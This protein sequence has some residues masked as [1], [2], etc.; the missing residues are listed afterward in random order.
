MHPKDLH[1]LSA[2]RLAFRLRIG[3]GE[4]VLPGPTIKL[5][6]FHHHQV[7][8]APVIL[9]FVGDRL[10]LVD[11]VPADSI[12]DVLHNAPGMIATM[13]EK[14]EVAINLPAFER[15]NYRSTFQCSNILRKGRGNVH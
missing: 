1:G 15:V 6:P 12:N 9:T 7:L 14:T 4:T 11:V 2:I 8:D 10:H 3:N 13:Y 5:G